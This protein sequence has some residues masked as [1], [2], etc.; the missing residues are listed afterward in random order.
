VPRII[1]TTLAALV[2]LVASMSA[3]L[4]HAILVASTV[5]D[6]GTIASTEREIRLTFSEAVEPR[7][8]SFKVEAATGSDAAVSV[9]FD[10]KDRKEVMLILQQP[11][12]AGSY[13]VRWKVVT[14]DTHQTEGRFV[15]A[16]R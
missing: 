13:R 9:V 3:V 15:F 1:R 12:P 4:A 2:A 5:A 14:A 16:I 6:G 10:D 11:L 7:F 8:S